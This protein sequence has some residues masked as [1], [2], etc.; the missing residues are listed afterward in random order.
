MAYEPD[1]MSRRTLDELG[2]LDFLRYKV[3]R[4]TQAE[5]EADPRYNKPNSL[6]EA[7]FSKLSI[8]GGIE[9]T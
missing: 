5:C 2:H 6:R 8:F 4:L 1:K 9:R 3:V 7:F